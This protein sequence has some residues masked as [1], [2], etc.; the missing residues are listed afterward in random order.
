MEPFFEVIRTDSVNIFLSEL[1]E[2]VQ[3][4]FGLG[5]ISHKINTDDS[6]I[7]QTH[8]TSLALF[9]SVILLFLI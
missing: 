4:S 5:H 9:V 2:Q 7:V 8:T 6:Y 3:P 1:D